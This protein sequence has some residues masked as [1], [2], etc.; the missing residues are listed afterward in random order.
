MTDVKERGF[1]LVLGFAGIHHV[2]KSLLGP[3]LMRDAILRQA[4]SLV[5]E[6]GF[7]RKALSLAPVSLS[8]NLTNGPL[9]EIAIT[10][11]FG[12]GD[13][14]RR[15]LVNAW[16]DEGLIEMGN[17][18]EGQKEINSIRAALRRRLSWNE[19]VLELLPEVRALSL[20]ILQWSIYQL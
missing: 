18:Q 9:S 16:L 13:D 19:P 11:L 20:Y 7:T 8:N 5:R 4:V 10:A 1:G 2:I 12:R 3:V 14:A 17:R 6:H 15:T